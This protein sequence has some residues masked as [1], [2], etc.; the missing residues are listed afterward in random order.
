M[1]ETG[2]KKTK[3]KKTKTTIELTR[4]DVLTVA[5]AGV[6]SAF[7]AVL[8]TSGPLSPFAGLMEEQRQGETGGGHGASGVYHWGMVIDLDKCI[9]CE[10][11]KRACSCYQQRGLSNRQTLEYRHR[12]KN[13]WRQP[14]LLH[15]ALPALPGCALR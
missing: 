14:V 7:A 11:C 2:E 8:V 12:R 13:L 10:Y 9:G 4:R 3:K 6:G 15:P 5:A 1:N